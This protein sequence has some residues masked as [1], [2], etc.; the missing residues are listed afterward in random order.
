M[1]TTII[2]LSPNGDRIIYQGE[3]SLSEIND[4]RRKFSQVSPEHPYISFVIKNSFF[5]FNMNKV[6]GIHILSE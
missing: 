6:K 4:L 3:A 1:L 2:E 5:T